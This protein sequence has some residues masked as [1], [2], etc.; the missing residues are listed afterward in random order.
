MRQTILLTLML[1]LATPDAVAQSQPIAALQT[2]RIAFESDSGDRVRALPHPRTLDIA[3]LRKH[4]Q[5]LAADAARI[6]AD[7]LTAEPVV[8]PLD[9]Q[10]IFAE[11]YRI[12]RLALAWHATGDAA[13]LNAAKRRALHVA[14]W[15]PNGLTGFRSH[16]QGARAIAWALALAFDWLYDQLSVEERERILG[17][18]RHRVVDMLAP[19]SKANPYGLDMGRT[20]D[21]NVHDSHGEVTLA[22][23]AVICTAL[24]GE[25]TLFD[26]CLNEV[27]PRY[28]KRPLSWGSDDGGFANGTSYAHWDVLSTHFVAWDL[29]RNAIGVN[30]WQRPWA[31]GYGRYIAYFLPPGAPTGLFGDEAE[32]RFTDVW[33]TQGKA[34]ATHLPSPLADWYA[35]NQSGE[36][37]GHLALLLAPSRDWSGIPSSL[38]IELPHAVYLADIGW[39]AMH[40]NLGDRTRTSVYFKSSPYG[41]YNH[42]HA[43][44]NSFVIHARGRAMAI[45]SGYYDAYGSPHWKEWYKQT[46]AHNAITFDGGQGQVHNSIAAKG[47]I[48]HFAHN[49]DFDVVSGDAT[50][51]YGGALTR[52]V[53]SLVYLRPDTLLVFDSLTSETPRTWEWNIHALSRMHE[54]GERSLE[55]ERDGVRMCVTMLEAPQG[56]FNQTD[57]FTAEPQGKYPSQW[58]AWYAT[59][60]KTS[61][62]EFV[63]S[64]VV[65]CQRTP[66]IVPMENGGWLVEADG[67]RFAFRD[68]RVEVISE[69]VWKKF[70]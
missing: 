56:V 25:A 62:T 48:A 65:G 50:Q 42:S 52:A 63:A 6:V 28:I 29:L 21:R 36:N 8:A 18:I 11:E 7:A 30:L 4:S 44:Q 66:S 54:K 61:Q 20:L 51:A 19:S 14:N 27:V 57:R 26:T 3:I 45:D 32:K 22:R 41:S 15:R 35:R 68:G 5:F 2:T 23:L 12:L 43:D 10:I 17:A 46:R 40:S 64:L 33:A 34:Y 49:S 69:G 53:R 31:R 70:N 59:R 67:R 38:P 16:D 60:E 47:R 13:F 37:P 58:H 1:V 9:Q 55:I 39:A 24:A